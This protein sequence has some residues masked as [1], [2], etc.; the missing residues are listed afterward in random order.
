MGFANPNLVR[1]HLYGDLRKEL[2]KLNKM[3]AHVEA[4]ALIV[5]V[6]IRCVESLDEEATLAMQN[7]GCPN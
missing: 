1:D 6:L 5:D 7:E 2:R 4:Q 3:K